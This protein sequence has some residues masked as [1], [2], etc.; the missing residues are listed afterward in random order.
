MAIASKDGGVAKNEVGEIGENLPCKV[1]WV[2]VNYM[3]F[4]L[5]PMG[6]LWIVLNK[7][8]HTM[9]WSLVVPLE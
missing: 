1:L 6:N 4:P 5:S 8:A 7:Q 2:L 3:E 9:R